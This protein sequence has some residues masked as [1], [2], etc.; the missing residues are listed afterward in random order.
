MYLHLTHL[1]FLRYLKSSSSFDIFASN[2]PCASLAASYSA[3]SERSPLSRASAICLIILG[4]S[5]VANDLT[6]FLN[7]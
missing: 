6:H 7:H 3:F 2:N 5:T 1:E 4:R